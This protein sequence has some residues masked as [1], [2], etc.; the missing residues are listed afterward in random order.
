MSRKYKF[1]NP[2]GLY[3]VT[4]TVVYWIDLFIRPEYH[5]IM[6]DSWKYCMK[7]KNLRIHAWCIMTS[8]VHMIISSENNL[9]AI[10]RD[11]KVIHPEG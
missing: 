8:H 5:E 6:L 2:D 1:R 9:W 11:M 4:Y 7:H 10:M 3:F